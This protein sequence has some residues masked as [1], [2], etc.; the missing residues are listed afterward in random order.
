LAA[1]FEGLAGVIGGVALFTTVDQQFFAS[2]ERN[3]FVIDVWMPPAT[4]LEETD[5]VIQRMQEF[6]AKKPMV[7]H[8][9]SFAGQSFPRFYYNVNPQEPD[10]RYGQIIVITKSAEETPPLV[11]TLQSEL[12][13][14]MPESFIMVKELQQGTQIESP[15]EVRIS[16]EDITV[17]KTL[18]DR[19][20][21]ILHG[22]PFATYTRDDYYDD[23]W[24]AGVNV[25]TE[26]AN[27]LGLTNAGIAGQLAGAFSGA[28]VTT[29]WEGDRQVNVLLR[30]DADQRQSFDNVRCVHH[31][32]PDWATSPLRS[33]ADITPQWQIARIVPE[34]GPDSD[35][36][37]FRKAGTLWLGGFE[38]N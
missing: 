21:G 19:V 25:R 6:V 13:D 15:V 18:G 28:P 32:Y 17:L 9:A 2:A 4:R 8:V 24:Y 12:R 31:F 27:R 1:D 3:Q 7:E 26:E 14:L 23:S 20:R 36:G 35:C 34:W 37:Q 38:G 5:R 11:K 33:V 30:L 22:V 10:A 16:G 29:F